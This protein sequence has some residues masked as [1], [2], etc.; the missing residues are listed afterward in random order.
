MN[1][2]IHI[3][4]RH[5]ANVSGTL[6]YWRNNSGAGQTFRQGRIRTFVY[7]KSFEMVSEEPELEEALRSGLS[8]C[9]DS[10]EV[11]SA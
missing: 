4:G 2:S 7:P 11:R 8:I 5:V 6:Y 9:L 10:V 1:C 3:Q